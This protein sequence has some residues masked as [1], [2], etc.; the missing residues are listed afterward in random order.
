[1]QTQRCIKPGPGVPRSCHSTFGRAP[2]AAIASNYY[3]F[4]CDISRRNNRPPD[5]EEVQGYGIE[6]QWLGQDVGR[7][8]HGDISA[9]ATGDHNT[10]EKDGGPEFVGHFN[11]HNEIGP[12][13]ETGDEFRYEVDNVDHNTDHNGGDEATGEVDEYGQQ[14]YPPMFSDGWVEAYTDDGN[15]NFFNQHTNASW[16]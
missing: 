16:I 5:T 15:V 11:A 14:Q 3:I 6:H 4:D 1:M 7:E 12:K 9:F 10:E 13:D 2:L 8:S